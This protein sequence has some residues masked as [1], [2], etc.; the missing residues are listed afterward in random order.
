MS[1]QVNQLTKDSVRVPVPSHSFIELTVF[2][3][4]KHMIP[5]EVF[6]LMRIIFLPFTYDPSMYRIYRWSV[7]RKVH[8]NLIL[9]VK[10]Y[11]PT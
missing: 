7:G 11:Q 10:L 2:M 9:L 8:S 3:V 6:N 1:Y 4:L 5:S